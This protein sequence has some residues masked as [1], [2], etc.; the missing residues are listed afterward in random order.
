MYLLVSMGVQIHA[1]KGAWAH[2]WIYLI[3]INL[4]KINIVF[5]RNVYYC[6]HFT[7]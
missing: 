7:K 1:H 6:D 3:K 5:K 4:L 2:A